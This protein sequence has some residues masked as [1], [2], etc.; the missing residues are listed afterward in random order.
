[1][2]KLVVIEG[3]DGSGK[4]TQTKQLCEHLARRGV[5]YK[6][7]SFPD[8]AHPSSSLVKMYLDGQLGSLDEINAYAASSFFS[9]DRYASYRMFWRQDYLAGRLIVADRYT[10]SNAS[11]QTAK[12][13]RDRWDAFLDWLQDF[14][15]RRLELPRPDCVILLDMHPNTSRKLLLERYH[16]DADKR[17]IHEADYDYLLACREGALYTAN[18]WGWQI[19]RCCDGNN[20]FPIEQIAAQV[21][22]TV[23][24]ILE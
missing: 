20:P 18:R 8:Y 22:A 10:T 21:A 12:L 16:G 9:V 15:Y 13:P 2:G 24:K 23:D 6:Q 19:I 14:E 1:M 7:I 5:D 11:H 17:D 4:A 3:L